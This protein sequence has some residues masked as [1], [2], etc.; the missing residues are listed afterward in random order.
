MVAKGLGLRI[1]DP[2]TPRLFGRAVVTRPLL[3]WVP[4][5]FRVVRPARTPLS[6]AVG[7]VAPGILHH[8]A[9]APMITVE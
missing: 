2:L 6:R 1:V 3:P 5:R 7:A 4:F 9:A 8:I